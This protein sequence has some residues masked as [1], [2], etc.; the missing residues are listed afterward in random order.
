[1]TKAK[2]L[3]IAGVLFTLCGSLM[4]A[5]NT[6]ADDF[7]TIVHHIEAEYHVH[8]NHRFLMSYAGMVVKCSRLA[9]LKAF[10]AALFEEQS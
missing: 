8:R 10:K 7:S 2:T 5:Q 3:R 1:M 9:G 4:L 6:N